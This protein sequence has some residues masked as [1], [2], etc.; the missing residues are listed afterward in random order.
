MYGFG[1]LKI[2]KIRS[3]IN[4]KQLQLLLYVSIPKLLAVSAYKGVA[5]YA[6]SKFY[7]NGHLNFTMGKRFD[8]N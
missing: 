7:P 2:N 4:D 3:K 8:S 5:K 1:K 6:G